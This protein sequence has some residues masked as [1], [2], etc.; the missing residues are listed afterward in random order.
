MHLR[1]TLFYRSFFGQFA[2]L[3]YNFALTVL[4]YS[5]L[6][7]IFNSSPIFTAVLAYFILNEPLVKADILAI[8]VCFCSVLLIAF[9]KQ[10][11]EAS[12][13]YDSI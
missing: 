1:R 2:F 9:G 12:V 4:P 3:C 10:S 8:L 5:T 13:F 7:V 6:F 11:K